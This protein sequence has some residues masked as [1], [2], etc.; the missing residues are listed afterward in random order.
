MGGGQVASACGVRGVRG[1]QC[2]RLLRAERDA[3]FAHAG[4]S[5]Q[6]SDQ[7]RTLPASL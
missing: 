2:D 7:T 6:V 3:H 1:E 4:T 5:Y